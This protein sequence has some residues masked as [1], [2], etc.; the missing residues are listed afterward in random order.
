MVKESRKRSSNKFKI[1][2]AISNN[3]LFTCQSVSQPDWYVF[4][5]VF[6]LTVSDGVIDGDGGLARFS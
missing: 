6:K 2:N 1:T 5:S 3:K 4:V